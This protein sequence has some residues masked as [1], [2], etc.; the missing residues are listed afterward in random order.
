MYQRMVK[1]QPVSI[2]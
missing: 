2:L 1:P